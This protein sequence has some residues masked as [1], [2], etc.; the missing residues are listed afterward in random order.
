MIK[1]KKVLSDKGPQGLVGMQEENKN[2]KESKV[3]PDG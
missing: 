2:T 1:S 3:I